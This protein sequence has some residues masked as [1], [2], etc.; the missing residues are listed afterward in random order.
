LTRAVTNIVENGV[1]HGSSVTVALGTAESANIDISDDG[2]GIPSELLEK[3]FEP[4]FKADSARSP[5]GARGFGLGL[6]IAREIVERHGGSITLLNGSPR[7]L[8]VRMM[9]N[10]PR[11]ATVL[12][13]SDAEKARGL[14]AEPSLDVILR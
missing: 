8:T 5:L 14:D 12:R 13:P 11:P 7:G 9:L 4:F 10:G 3:V 2:P 6:S 1:K